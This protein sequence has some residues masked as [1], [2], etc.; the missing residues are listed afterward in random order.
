MKITEGHRCFSITGEE[1]LIHSRAGKHPVFASGNSLEHTV[2]VAVS[3]LGPSIR[4]LNLYKVP[5]STKAVRD[6]ILLT[7]LEHCVL[8]VEGMY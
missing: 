6:Q 3:I 2:M 7:V 5:S 4:L 1:G 8:W